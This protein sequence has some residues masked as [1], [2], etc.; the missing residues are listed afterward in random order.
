[1]GEFAAKGK[2][3]FVSGQSLGAAVFVGVKSTQV[4]E[5][6]RHVGQVGAG[7]G[8]GEF[9]VKL[10]GFLVRLP[11]FLELVLLLVKVQKNLLTKIYFIAIIKLSKNK[12]DG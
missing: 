7:V 5:R 8:L 1:L 3:L 9:A 4:V 11:A 10:E 6:H 2:S 12:G